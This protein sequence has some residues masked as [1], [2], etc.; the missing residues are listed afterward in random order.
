[1]IEQL[2]HSQANSPVTVDPSGEVITPTRPRRIDLAT[3]D[4]CRLEMAT[5]YRAMKSGEIETSE[6]TKLVYVLGQ[7]GRLIEAHEIEKRIELLETTLSKR[8]QHVK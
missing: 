8:K 2:K 3:I 4:D 5:V 6:G 1:M 7:L